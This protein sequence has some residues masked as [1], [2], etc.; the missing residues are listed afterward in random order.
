MRRVKSLKTMGFSQIFNVNKYEMTQAK[1]NYYLKYRQKR[2]A[3]SAG[4]YSVRVLV[5]IFLKL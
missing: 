1:Q 2:G 5:E 3:S 4:T